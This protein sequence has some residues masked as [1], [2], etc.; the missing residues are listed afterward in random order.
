MKQ[1]ILLTTLLMS[2]TFY[3][4]TTISGKVTD[5]K[6]E[7]IL[8][9]NVYLNGTYDGTST[10]EKGEFFFTSNETGSQTLVVSFLS[11]EEYSLTG[12]ISTFNKLDIKLKEDVNTLDAVIINAGTFEAG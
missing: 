8:G 4:Q 2:V 9:A 1:L 12:D 5:T 3:A 6:G 11:F 10:N 7:A